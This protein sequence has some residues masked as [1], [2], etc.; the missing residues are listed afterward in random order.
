MSKIKDFIKSQKGKRI[1]SISALVLWMGVIFFFS[2]QDDNSSSKASEVFENAVIKATVADIDEKPLGDRNYILFKVERFV[3]TS[4]HFFCFAVLG[5]LSIVVLN[6]YKI[7]NLIKVV[8]SV[9]FGSCNALLDEV[10]QYFV[11]GRTFEL[12]DIGFDTV[13]VLCGVFL[14]VAVM[15]IIQLTRAQKKEAGNKDVKNS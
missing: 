2:A 9:L 4:A 15:F 7:K 11:P 10:H 6:T 8:V 3:R 5:V 1:L 13:G 14:S 12:N